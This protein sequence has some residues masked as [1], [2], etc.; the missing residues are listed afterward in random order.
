MDGSDIALLAVVGVGGYLIYRAIGA[1]SQ[2]FERKV[3]DAGLGSTTSTLAA[4][5]QRA[6]VS[7]RDSQTLFFP[8]QNSNFTLGVSAQ[9]LDGA[10]PF[11]R[12][13]LAR[14]VPIEQVETASAQRSLR[15]IG[16]REG[17]GIVAPFI[18]TFLG[19]KK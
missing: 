18:K 5:S 15:A 6:D 19:W 4:M 13:Q 9:D 14:G 17:L 11:E 1:G 7:A 10:S 16:L 3:A 12:G 8:S 2:Y